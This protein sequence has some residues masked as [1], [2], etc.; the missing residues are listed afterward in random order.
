MSCSGIRL[1]IWIIGGQ[2]FFVSFVFLPPSVCSCLAF[3]KIKLSAVFCI[4]M[5]NQ[6]GLPVSSVSNQSG[7][8]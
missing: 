5:V 4:S 7:I 2:I 8:L 6:V 1:P 3:G